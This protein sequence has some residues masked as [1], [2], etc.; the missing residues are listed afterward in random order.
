MFGWNKEETA[1]KVDDDIMDEEAGRMRIELAARSKARKAEEAR[2]MAEQNAAFRAKLGNVEVKTDHDIMDEEAGR[3]RLELAA[4]SKARRE[5]EQQ[6][7]AER[8]RA[9][10]NAWKTTEQRTD[11]D[12]TDEGMRMYALAYARAE[13]R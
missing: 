3:R 8:E 12:I 2:K 13:C 11:D 10:R 9:L 6:R 7:L 5:A 4:A 1:P